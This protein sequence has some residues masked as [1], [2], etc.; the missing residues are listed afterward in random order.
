MNLLLLLILDTKDEW[1]AVESTGVFGELPK[2]TE[3]VMQYGVP[4]AL[5]RVVFRRY[6]GQM[7]RMELSKEELPNYRLGVDFPFLK[8]LCLFGVN[9]RFKPPDNILTRW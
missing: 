7:E 4:E 2:L 9:T 8:H 5:Q 6:S 1:D 3:A